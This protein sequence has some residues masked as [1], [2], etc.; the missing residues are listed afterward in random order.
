MISIRKAIIPVAGLGTRFLPI[1]KAIPKEMLPILDAP[2]AHYIV[3]EALHANINEIIFITNHN[4]PSIQKYFDQNPDFDKVTF[5]YVNQFEQL[6]LGHAVSCAEDF[7]CD[8]P[9]LVMLGDLI[10]FPQSDFLASM[11]NKYKQH[12]KNI[13]AVHK[14]KD[15]E[16]SRYGV[17]NG[18]ENNN[19]TL[20]NIHS[21]AEKPDPS[22]AP[23][24][25]A[26][27]GRYILEPRVFHH[28]RQIKSGTGGEYQLTDALS[29][30]SNEGAL[31][32]FHLQEQVFDTGDK[33]QYLMANIEFAL[34]RTDLEEELLLKLR[35]KLNTLKT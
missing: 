16:I 9:F 17:V 31:M 5:T 23:G 4:K 20:W 25:W 18:P 2:I 24:P 33:V 21:M 32:A 10:F 27:P 7:V 29:L 14:V 35:R 28:L 22:N 1:T 26:I 12:K 19:M 11:I 3:K 30:L 15:Y 34:R 13:I 8:E 6:G